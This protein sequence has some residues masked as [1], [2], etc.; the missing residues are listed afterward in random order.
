M[1][2]HVRNLRRNYFRELFRQ[3]RRSIGD[4]SQERR[5]DPLLWAKETQRQREL[6]QQ[7]AVEVDS[8][9]SDPTESDSAEVFETEDLPD[10]MLLAD[11]PV[12]ADPMEDDLLEVPGVKPLRPDK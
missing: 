11:S 7:N 6:V 10:C 9:T 3:S 1:I 2:Y 5:E 4:P 8:T 12:P